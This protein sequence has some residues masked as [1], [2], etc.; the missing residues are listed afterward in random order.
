M[1]KMKKAESISTFLGPGA[2]VQGIIEFKNT[3]RLDGH[4]KGK[5]FSQAG[6]VII[7]AKALI[8]AEIIVDVA[9]V[10]GK[11][12][13]TIEAR[14]RIEVYPPGRIVGDIQAP[15]IIIESGVVFYGNCSMK[16]VA[17]STK[18]VPEAAVPGK[19]SI[20]TKDLRATEKF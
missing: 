2:S 5:V 4:V 1:K 12:N 10:M 11:V 16:P 7:G 14:Q 18:K 9:I 19:E 20:Q 17:V 13:G 3:I 6:T 15:T 8:D